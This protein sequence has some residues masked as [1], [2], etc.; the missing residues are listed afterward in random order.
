MTA[1]VTPQWAHCARPVLPG[2]DGVPVVLMVATPDTTVRDEA[3]VLVRTALRDY[4]APLIGC[5]PAAVPLL[6]EP[7]QAPRL[8]LADWPL[9][10]SIS[11]EAGLTLAALRSGGKVGV[12][13]MRTADAPLPDWEALAHDYLGPEVVAR[14]SRL[15]AVERPHGFAQ[16]WSG[17]E[18]ALK[19]LGL[20]L[21]EWTPALARALASCEVA[22]L[23]LP[24]GYIGA[25]A[26][27]S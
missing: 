10:L 20:P 15:G 21:Q 17:H 24:D 16:A 25:M 5:A 23:A 11:H 7:G 1:L 13:L 3:R 6:I 26:R 18:A 19:C 12:D 22:A 4:L 14:L 8:A 9:H 27:G 2:A